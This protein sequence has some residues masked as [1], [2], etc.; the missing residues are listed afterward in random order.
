MVHSNII[1]I[2]FP[3]SNKCF[4]RTIFNTQFCINFFSNCCSYTS[5]HACNAQELQILTNGFKESGGSLKI[6][7]FQMLLQWSKWL[8]M[9]YIIY[10]LMFITRMSTRSERWQIITFSSNLLNVP[11]VPIPLWRIELLHLG[12][13]K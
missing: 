6:L 13:Q 4:V 7:R 3:K 5:Y 2:T 11:T 10:N 12:K 8:G 1:F 9:A